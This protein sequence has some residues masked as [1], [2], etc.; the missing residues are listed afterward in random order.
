M[1][2]REPVESSRD[3]YELFERM[4]WDCFHFAYEHDL[5]GEVP[6]STDCGQPGCPSSED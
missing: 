3:D 6:Q 5:Y 1:R 2:C 4:H